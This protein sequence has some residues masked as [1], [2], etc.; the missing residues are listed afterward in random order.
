MSVSAREKELETRWEDRVETALADMSNKFERMSRENNK[1]HGDVLLEI[2]NLS[3]RMD[4]MTEKFEK[5]L[6]IANK[7]IESKN[8]IIRVLSYGIVATVFMMLGA[9]ATLLGWIK[10]VGF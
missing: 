5:A 6:E 4:L 7:K 1:Q 3:G 2:N 10:T 9:K 8:K